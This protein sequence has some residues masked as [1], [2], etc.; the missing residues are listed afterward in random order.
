MIY[1]VFRGLLLMICAIVFNSTR[2]AVKLF[3]GFSVL[4]FLFV[5]ILLSFSSAC[6]SMDYSSGSSEVKPG[7]FVPAECFTA[8]HS[9]LAYAEA[10][11]CW[12]DASDKLP[13]FNRNKLL[14]Y[15]YSQAGVNF[16][17][18]G[19]YDQAQGLFENVLNLDRENLSEDTP[20]ALIAMN[21]LA[22]ALSARNDLTSAKRLHEKNLE[23]A[24]SVLGEEHPETLI[25]MNNLAETMV[26]LGNLAEARI[27]QEKVWEIK[28]RVLGPGSPSTLKSMNNLASILH[29]QGEFSKALILA[30]ETYELSMLMLGDEDPFTLSS[31][32]NLAL[33]HDAAGDLAKARELHEKALEIK[34]RVLGEEHPSTLVS[35]NNLAETM[36]A[37]GDFFAAKKL[38]ETA[39][40]VTARV[41]G[42][43][44]PGTTDTAW[45]LYQI[46][47]HLG[48]AKVA[49]SVFDEHLKWLLEKKPET[50]ND[51]QLKIR[52][53]MA[54]ELS[55]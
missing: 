47:Q 30:K 16:F 15:Y 1:Y 35:M 40:E 31:M 5:L 43:D 9:S 17:N 7:I 13:L 52:G 21:N 44:H 49:E 48:E 22:E 24:E 42:Q 12:L 11:Y 25:F 34:L 54:R 55:K 37:Q 18:A 50:L 23:L 26:S 14:S 6:A 2:G 33:M 36:G 19:Q 51:G 20:D 32:N 27:L 39:L 4:K 41:L 45:K 10:A 53:M 29:M 38:E 28:E 3:H 46:L 8:G